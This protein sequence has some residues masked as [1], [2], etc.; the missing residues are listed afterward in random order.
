MAEDE[1]DDTS[2]GFTFGGKKVLK[3]LLK[4]IKVLLP[5]FM[6]VAKFLMVMNC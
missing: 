5:W 4:E 2:L 6:F 1:I 3:K